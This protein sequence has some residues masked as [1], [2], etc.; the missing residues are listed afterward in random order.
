MKAH[1]PEWDITRNLE[2]TF[3]EIIDSWRERL[4]AEKSNALA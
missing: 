1:Y 2:E 3:T 4:T